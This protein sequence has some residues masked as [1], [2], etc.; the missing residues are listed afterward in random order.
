M[1][2]AHNGKVNA[3]SENGT[4]V[5]ARRSVMGLPAAT[6]RDASPLPPGIGRVA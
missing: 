6:A 5:V 1:G 4:E 2:S 3:R